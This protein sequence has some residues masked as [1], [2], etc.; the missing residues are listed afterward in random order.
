MSFL[1]F[2]IVFGSMTMNQIEVVTIEPVD[3]KEWVVPWESSRPRDPYVDHKGL[4]WFVGQRSHYIAYLE[5]ETG[6]FKRYELEDGAGPHNLIVDKEGFVW[7]AGN[8]KANIGKLNPANGDITLYPMPEETAFD[9]HTL[10]FDSAGDIWFTAQRSNYIGKLNTKTGEVRLVKV[11]AERSLPYGIKVNEN[12]RP[13]IVLFGKNRIATVDPKSFDLKEIE[14]P[15]TDARPRRIEI[16][17]DANLWYVDYA[18]GYLGRYNPKSSKFK[19][20]QVPGGESARPYGM[21]IDDKDRIW[22][23]ESGIRP[24][25]LVGFDPKSEEFFTI[26]EIKSGGGTV[27]HMYYL[28]ASQEVWF[29]TDTNTIGRARLPK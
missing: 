17:S 15:R 29:G 9:P 4:V 12:D 14:I 16:D 11:P 7:Y 6:D 21:A 18:K 26:T 13:W 2:L 22:F 10:V 3:I 23:V 25:R 24:N 19:E 8:R 5:P 28:Q 20:W 27:R 1:M